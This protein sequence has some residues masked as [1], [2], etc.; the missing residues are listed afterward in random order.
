KVEHYVIATKILKVVAIMLER[1][2]SVLK[3]ES[4]I[5][6]S[7]LIKFLSGE[8]WQQAI[9]VEVLH[10]ICWKPRQLRDICQ[11]Y[12]LQNKSNGSTPVFQELINALASLT[13]AKFHRLYRNK[14]DPES[15]SDAEILDELSISKLILN[16][17]TQGG[18]KYYYLEV[19][20]LIFTSSIIVFLQTTPT[21]RSEIP[22]VSEDYVLRMSMSCLLD[23]ATAIIDLGDKELIKRRAA[24][25]PIHEI[26]ETENTLRQMIMSGW[27]GLL[28]TLSLLFE[29]APDENTVNSVLDLMT[30]LTAVAG[31]LNMDGPREALVGTLCRFA[32]PPGYHEKSYAGEQTSGSG[33]Q[34]LVVGQPLTASTSSGAGFVLLTTRNI[35]VLRALL[36]VASDY[37]PLLGQSW[38][39]VLSAL[40][41]LSWILGFQ[42]SI[43]GEMTAKVQEKGQSTVLTT[44]IIQEIPKISKKL[45]DVF[46]NS[47]KLD[48]V[49]L[50][51]LVNA[52]CELSTETMDQAYGSATREPSLF[53]VANLV[54]VSITNLNRLEVIWRLVTG[55]LL[56]VC[57]HTN[58]HFRK[59][60]ADGISHLIIS[61]FAEDSIFSNQRRQEM[62]LAAFSEMST[63]PK[64]DVRTRQMQCVLEVLESRGEKLTSA[65]PVL[66]EI[67]QASC[68]ALKDQGIV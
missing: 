56:E 22:F 6:L 21:D 47:S 67:I 52:I 59:T 45:A 53:A 15:P 29:A 62:V 23:I 30:A 16:S 31:G 7:F 8:Q 20:M 28:Q 68:E 43:T 27:S 46:E 18:T 34:V 24:N 36:D 9:A 44:A 54:Q 66:L 12:D 37:G 4:E 39:L 32:L 48:E 17:E 10:K 5:F 61:A 63:I 64:I 57:Q 40:Q 49:A 58:M 35:Q 38:S 42:C 60:G 33:G 50:H 41:H 11:Q 13:S 65:W 3:T 51:H 2:N 1:Y 19:R 25:V 26:N 14:E 55:H